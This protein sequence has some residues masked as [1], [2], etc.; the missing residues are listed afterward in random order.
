MYTHTH[1]HTHTSKCIESPCVQCRSMDEWKYSLVLCLRCFTP[2][3]PEIES[4]APTEFAWWVLEPIHNLCIIPTTLSRLIRLC[5]A[6][7][8]TA[9]PFNYVAKHANCRGTQYARCFSI[10]V[11]KPTICTYNIQG[12]SRL[13]DITAGGDFQGLCD[14]K[15][16]INMCPIL[17]GYGVM[18]A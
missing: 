18:A 12:V 7:T 3:P 11:I 9:R 15:V 6:C 10:S 1:T 4:L 5:S 2:S 8:C 17:D 16:R 13:V 14:K